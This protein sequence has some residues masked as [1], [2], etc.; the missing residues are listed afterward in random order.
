MHVAAPGVPVVNRSTAP[1]VLACG[2]GGLVLGRA[3]PR[4]APTPTASIVPVPMLSASPACGAERMELASVRAQLGVCNARLA[5]ATSLDAGTATTAAE[6]PAVGATAR[7]TV[8]DM[9][10]PELLAQL[11][12][13]GVPAS[14]LVRHRDGTV[15]SHT[16]EDWPADTDDG[17]IIAKTFP[18][19]A[20]YYLPDA[21]SDDDPVAL[22]DLVPD[23]VVMVGRT[24]IHVPRRRDA[25][26]GP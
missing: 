10:P 18:G 19:R 3:I 24:R 5:Q 9:F 23:G 8:G 7:S 11:V 6:A 2:I 26:A 17:T 25:D 20:G 16:R 14:V 15:S 22:R 1:L 12:D 4:D 13:A 21:G